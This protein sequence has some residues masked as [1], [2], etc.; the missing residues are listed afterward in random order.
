MFAEGCISASGQALSNSP[1][2]VKGMVENSGPQDKH[3]PS[4][5]SRGLRRRSVRGFRD[6]Q[7]LWTLKHDLAI[8]WVIPPSSVCLL[9]QMTFAYALAW[10]LNAH[11]GILV[12]L[13]QT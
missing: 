1:E 10:P 2:M 6:G 4:S 3:A 5:R 11:A 8:D 9:T 7:T 13:P 12:C